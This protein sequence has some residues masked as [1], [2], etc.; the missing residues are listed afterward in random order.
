MRRAYFILAFRVIL[1][2]FYVP[3]GGYGRADK[4][5]I[6]SSFMATKIIAADEIFTAF[7][8]KEGRKHTKPKVAH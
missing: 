6:F 1:L 8:T 7:S 4:V 5:V 2:V 3:F